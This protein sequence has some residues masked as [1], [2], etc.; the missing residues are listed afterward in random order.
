MD[1]SRVLAQRLTSSGFVHRD[2]DVASA[3]RWVLAQRT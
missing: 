1:S 3:L 2:P